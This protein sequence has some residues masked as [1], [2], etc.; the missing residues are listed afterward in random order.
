[1]RF[2]LKNK[3]AGKAE[4]WIEDYFPGDM[5]WTVVAVASLIITKDECLIDTIDTKPKY[6]CKGYA[7]SIIKGLQKEFRGVKPI[8]VIPSSQFFWDKFGMTD[9][10]GS[11]K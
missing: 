5:D 7:T 6:R 9:A 4:A 1:M 11:E 2:F 8:G 10:L 3:G